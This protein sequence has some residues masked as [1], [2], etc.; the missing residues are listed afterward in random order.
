MAVLGGHHTPSA[1]A[2]NRTPPVVQTAEEVPVNPQLPLG[3]A[4][5][6]VVPAFVAF[7]ASVEASPGLQLP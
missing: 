6:A 1:A 4:V 5:L 2:G 7:A 3:L